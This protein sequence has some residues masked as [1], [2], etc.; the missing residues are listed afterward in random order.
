MGIFVENNFDNQKSLRDARA[1][2]QTKQTPHC[3]IGS[4]LNSRHQRCCP[5]CEHKTDGW[6]VDLSDKRGADDFNFPCGLRSVMHFAPWSYSYQWMVWFEQEQFRHAHN[7]WVY[8]IPQSAAWTFGCELS[9]IN[10]E[11]RSLH[12]CGLSC[13]RNPTNPLMIAAMSCQ[14]K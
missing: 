13:S 7:Y 1:N 2:I 6:A 9:N 11:N 12:C 10:R 5:Q 4:E 8:K 14:H 3:C